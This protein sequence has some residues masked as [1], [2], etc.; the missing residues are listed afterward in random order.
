M[1]LRGEKI[2]HVSAMTDF[3]SFYSSLNF[4]LGGLLKNKTEL[5]IKHVGIHLGA[6]S[7]YN[8]SKRDTEK[9][10]KNSN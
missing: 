4:T 7:Q 1:S 3:M 5:N 9:I 10:H 6:I 8:R 2:F